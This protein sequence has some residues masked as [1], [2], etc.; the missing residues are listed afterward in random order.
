MS[1]PYCDV[2]LP[3][4]LDQPFTYLL[5]ETLRHRVKTG[6]R[7]LV[8]FGKRTV[9]G[10]VL[11][12]H[13]EPPSTQPREALR[14]LDEEP[15]LDASLLK[16]GRWIS[17][18]YCAPLGE[19]LRAMTPLAADI[20]HGKLYSL[21]SSGHDAARQFRFDDSTPDP[22]GELLRLLDVRPL[23]GAHLARKVPKAASI[24]RAL[25][26]KGLVEAE[27]RTGARRHRVKVE[28]PSAAAIEP[29]P[30][31]VP[32]E[33]RTLNAHQ[34]VAFA[35]IH[36]ALEAGRFAA[37]LLE[38]ITGSGKTEV[39]LSAIEATLARGK[40]ALLL[41]PEIGLTPAVADQFH[42]RFG[43]RAAIL[44]SAFQ[45]T[46]RAEQWR[47]IRSGGAGVVVATRSGVFAPLPDLGLIV[48]DEEHDQSYKQQEAPRYSGRD[49]AVVRARNEGAVVVLGSATPSL[50]TRYN[51]DKGKYTRLEL[52]E[53][54]E[55]RPLPQVE[56]IDMRQEFL[57]TRKQ[58]TF[59]RTLIDAVTA[60]LAAGEQTMLLLNRRG[61]SS[62]VVC[63]ACGQRV[64]C[65]NCSVTLTF[66]RRDRR[67]LCHYCN[68]S[69]R[70]PNRCP[71]CDSEHV[72]FVGVGSE[73]VEDEIHSAFPR[74]RV[75]RLDRDTVRGKNDYER[76]LAGF[77]GGAF[78][79]LVGTQMIAK[80]HDIPNVT[81]VGIVNADVGL[82]LPD[83][84][85]AE[86]TF[87]LLTQAAGRAGRGDIP[88]IVLIQ[89]INPEHYAI[90]CAAAQNY[91]MF[92][93]K[94]I[95][96]RRLMWY[97]PFGALA[98]LVVRAGRE[99]EALTRSGALG[100]LLQPAP[101]GVKVLGPAPAA[102]A[103]LKNEYRFQMLL[104]TSS[105]ARLSE[106]LAEV[107]RFA[108]AE[109]WPAASLL[110]DVD[111]MTLL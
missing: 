89:T 80:G 82:G 42:R 97:P 62:F 13:S 27:D 39:Y 24:L 71:K 46:E 49:V 63:R 47:R 93:A 43:E 41:V 28:T 37:F 30:E 36:S 52:P 66:H 107:R 15:V 86:R 5:P 102:V 40:S 64:E 96:F 12:T 105:R 84:R 35:S 26:K 60:R 54:I 16:L 109:R 85:A 106:I 57:E 101:E 70:I 73:K 90:R 75:A 38:G 69:T 83:F 53:R 18:Y 29:A 103:R 9:A 21:T 100:R 8:P 48:V 67:M 88:G 34:A 20:R 68:Y 78:D 6:C 7:V 72:Q 10:V 4:P 25:E 56:L 1:D 94:E 92:Y 79:I 11:R 58:G 2:S 22:A 3:V 110:I 61:F 33:S 55:R 59:S 45:D 23:T 14:L 98:N 50:E 74:A 91:E 87:Q 77:R 51:A 76:I 111:P 95:E 19:T 108:A 99:E 32:R 44:H 65:V 31:W 81:L 17:E 104:K